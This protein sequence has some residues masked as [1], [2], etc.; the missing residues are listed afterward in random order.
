M[1]QL[2]NE[3]AYISIKRKKFHITTSLSVAGFALL[4]YH[5]EITQFI[6][7]SDVL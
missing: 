2:K 5:S 3:Y 1:R 4:G 6:M 7:L